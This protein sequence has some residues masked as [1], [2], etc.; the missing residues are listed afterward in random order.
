MPEHPSVER[1]QQQ[2]QQCLRVGATSQGLPVPLQAGQVLFEAAAP[3]DGL[4][5]LESGALI[6]YIGNPSG[7]RIEL[8]KLSPG[9]VIGE[10]SLQG[11]AT[12]S[13]S[14]ASTSDDTLLL[15]INR[16]QAMALIDADPEARQA[17]VLILSERARSMVRFIHDFSHL[18]ELVAKGD[19]EGVQ[20][21]I[22]SNGNQDPAVRAA[23]DAFNTM[24]NRV[25]QRESE[26]QTRIAS[27]SLEIDHQRAAQEVDAILGGISF[28]TLQENAANLRR[29][30][31]GD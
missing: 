21:L 8:A 10:M 15:F 12:R 3:S 18:T 16:E 26:L 5:V 29:R 13:D 4:Y 20:T 25:R 22:S 31:R 7:D 24:L 30:L 19:Y 27:L 11:E 28:Q 1:A 17:L 14:C 23:R 6:I 2:L 9:A